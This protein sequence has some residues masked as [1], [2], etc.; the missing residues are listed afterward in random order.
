MVT[1]AACGHSLTASRHSPTVSSGDISSSAKAPLTTTEAMPSLA[2]MNPPIEPR[3]VLLSPSKPWLSK[4]EMDIS[5]ASISTSCSKTTSSFMTT[6]NNANK[7][8]PEEEF[9]PN[10][11]VHEYSTAPL[12][13]TAGGPTSIQLALERTSISSR[14]VS[15][16]STE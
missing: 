14:F 13:T 9:S 10:F 1:L 16:P 6:V 5:A 8:A 11:S 3:L 15:P 2:Y 12:G 7:A 4:K